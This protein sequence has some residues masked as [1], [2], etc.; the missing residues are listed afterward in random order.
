MKI[1]IVGAGIM[2]RLLAFSSQE[3]GFQVTLFDQ[4]GENNCSHAAAGLLAP[5]TELEKNDSLIFELGIDAL[6]QHWPKLMSQLGLQS[7]F[8]QNGILAVSHPRDRAELIR[9][10]QMIETKLIEKDKYQYVNH[11][12]ISALEPQIT[13]FDEGLF[14][15][16]EGQLDTRIMLSTLEKRLDQITWYKNTFVQML[17]PHTVTLAHQSYHFDIVLDC[18]GLGA[19]SQ[20]ADL[21]SIRGELIWLHAPDVMIKRPIRLMH[22]RYSLYVVPRSD[23]IYLVGASEIESHDFS[24]ISVRTLF[25]L[26][27]AVYSIHSGFSEARLMKTVTQCRPTLANH[28]PKIKYTD[29]LLAINGLYRHGYLI[30]PTL[31]AEVMI[32]IK[33]GINAIHYPE[34][35]EECA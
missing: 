30:A 6:T 8:K 18:R 5:I 16:E 20:F 27:T 17:A 34:V 25:E 32:S 11:T 3:A 9:L 23:H 14:F 22:P 28:L 35:W 1:G 13:K 21:R 10:K 26:L 29:G 7:I 15:P 2:G 19:T 24:P 4:G 12:Q 33:Q 31:M